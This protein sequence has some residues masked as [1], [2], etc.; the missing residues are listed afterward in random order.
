M[1]SLS[2]VIELHESA[3]KGSEAA[4]EQR[5]VELAESRKPLG[6]PWPAQP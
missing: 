6:T 5:L 3:E 1:T 4:A 2:F